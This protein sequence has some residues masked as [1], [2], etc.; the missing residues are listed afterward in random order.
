MKFKLHSLRRLTQKLNNMKSSFLTFV[1]LLVALVVVWFFTRS[2]KRVAVSTVDGSLSFLGLA[3]MPI[4]LRNNN[5][6][7]IRISSNPWKGKL[8]NR[9]PGTHPAF[10]AFQ[11]VYY[12]IRAAIVNLRTHYKRGN[13]TLLQ[14]INIWAPP[15]DK[16]DTPA[17]VKFVSERTGIPPA[18]AFSWEKE[19]VVKIITAMSA[20]EN[21]TDTIKFEHV[22]RAWD[23]V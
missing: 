22:R 19:N 3:N 12:G 10:E 23:M 8:T 6:L 14:L 9:P 5:P 2:A 15:A 16:N 7:N 20:M 21:G 17:Y 13:T 1:I 11:D 4:G 18:A